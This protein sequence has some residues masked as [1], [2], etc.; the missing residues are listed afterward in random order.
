M[1]GMIPDRNAFLSQAKRTI[2]VLGAAFE[3]ATSLS[4]ANHQ[5]PRP[6]L[7][8]RSGDRGIAKTEILW[9]QSMPTC[10]TQSGTAVSATKIVHAY[11][12][13][14]HKG[15]RRRVFRKIIS[16]HSM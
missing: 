16:V 11:G 3:A 15:K 1:I 5:P 7:S 12:Q 8:D 14:S 9:S 6:L 13:Q 2:P 10:G 4:H